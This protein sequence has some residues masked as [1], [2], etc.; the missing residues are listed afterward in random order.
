MIQ[1]ELA[2]MAVLSGV[3]PRAVHG[4]GR[5]PDAGADP[6]RAEA[7]RVLP[8]RPGRG[9]ARE[10]PQPR[11]AGRSTRP[12]RRAPASTACREAGL[13]L[14]VDGA[15]LWNAAVAL[16]VEPRDAG[17]R[18]RHADGHALEGPVRAGRLAAARVA[19]LIEKARRVRKQL[20]GGMRQVGRAGRGG[21]RRA[22]D[23][24]PAPRRGPRQR[25][26]A[27]GGARQAAAARAC[28]AGAPTSSWRRS[29]AAVRPRSSSP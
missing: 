23:D 29:R 2:G 4:P 6:R 9:R 20:G 3:I 18:S 16:G 12:S 15:R 8:L 17:R 22:R 5:P 21:D 10:H 11:A 26:A 25:A 24:D 27:G 14:H 7:V 13:T 28:A 1:Y 19:P